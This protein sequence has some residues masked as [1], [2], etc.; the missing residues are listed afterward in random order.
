MTANTIETQPER[1]APGF[2]TAVMLMAGKGTR[3]MPAG[4]K[5]PNGLEMVD[6]WHNAFGVMTEGLAA[7]GVKRLVVVVRN[8]EVAP[9]VQMTEVLTRRWLAGDAEAQAALQ[10]KS[11]IDPRVIEAAAP[12]HNLH[13]IHPDDVHFAV[14]SDKYGT[15]S[16]FAA[17]IPTLRKI[18]AEASLVVNSDAI[19]IGPR[20]SADDH[21]PNS[22]WDFADL[23]NKM[24][25]TG[26]EHGLLAAE[27]EPAIG[28][29]GKYTYGM[30]MRDQDGRFTHILEDARHADVP[31]TYDEN[32]RPNKLWANAGGY[33]VR[34]SMYD[35]VEKQMSQTLEELGTPE[36]WITTPFDTAAAAG[37]LVLPKL[38]VSQFAD[39]ADFD[40][41]QEAARKLAAAGV[42]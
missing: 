13:G 6:K 41:R 4:L 25:A 18:G 1:I 36:Y 12:G 29:T 15:A 14:Q 21:R 31:V 32:G 2:E 19:L 23:T 10:K 27:R 7:V 5:G 40:D 16:S 3:N 24:L 8:D 28:G 22:G 11:G 39:C 33:A 30:I 20:L 37:Q 26:A 9:G 35:I 42:H 17:A 34:S 38:M